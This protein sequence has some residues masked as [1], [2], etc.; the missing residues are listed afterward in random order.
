MDNGIKTVE[1]LKIDRKSI[2]K[3]ARI[4]FL[5]N[6][7]SC[8]I[9]T[10]I[11]VTV[12]GGGY[13]YST[14]NTSNLN[15]EPTQENIAVQEDLPQN[16]NKESNS[17][18]VNKFLKLVFADNEK[19]QDLDEKYSNQYNK[20]IVS[21]ILNEMN[22][23]KITVGVMNSV[24]ILLSG[25]SFHNFALSLSATILSLLLFFMIKQVIII[26]K[27]RF[28]LEDRRYYETK[29]DKILFPYRVKRTKHIASIL[30][31]KYVY[32][33]LWTITIVGGI[34]KYYEY[35]FVP[36]VLAENPTISKKEAFRLSKE[37][38]KGIKF[39]IFKLQL[40]LLG[41]EILS[42]FTL[43]LVNILFLNPYEEAIYAELYMNVRKQKYDQ[44]TDKALLNDSYLDIDNVVKEE[45]PKEKYNIRDT[46]KW[47]HFDYNRRYTI[48]NLILFF[49]TFSFIGYAYEVFIHI[50]RDGE[51]VNRG[52]LYGPWLPIYG[53]GGVLILVLLK[54]FR[55]KP[56]KLFLS[57]IILCGIVEYTGAWMLET[58]KHMKYW[59]YSGY[60][61]N[62]QGRVC[63]EGLMV[64]GLGG[65]AFTYILGP[66]L[67]NLCNKIN[68]KRK[69]IL[70]AILLAI[71][72]VDYVCASIHPNA[73][74]GITD[75]SLLNIDKN[76][77]Q[78]KKIS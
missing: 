1:K 4:A 5:K 11:A 64:F 62:I 66:L 25:D 42:W 67:D 15:V 18:I 45:Y 23:G 58:F 51:F 70:C 12:L 78:D 30:F 31:W 59:D 29:I 46:V 49:F 50:V 38:S 14:N 57:A 8:I 60:F 74:K 75:Y 73:G 7:F 26:G 17:D 13:F 69:H 63:F 47:L 65:C 54:R 2:K 53:F 44:L 10:F 55:D 40:S 33:S 16:N 24:S 37:L 22:N 56:W 52:S 77:L 71:I 68:P 20:G 48:S 36:Y 43:G 6:Y 19:A 35:F 3:N 39:E 34:Y 21:T 28:F 32:E 9:V 72:G 76:T 61:L 27:I 41:Y